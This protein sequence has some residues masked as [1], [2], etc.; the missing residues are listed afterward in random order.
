MNLLVIGS[1]GREHA[2]AW[3]I[4]QSRLAGKVYCAP[5][6]P[7]TAK[8]AENIPIGVL[9]FDQLVSFA[10]EKR[11]DLTVVGPED[12]L[13]NGIVDTFHKHDLKI[14]GPDKKAARL[15]GSKTFAKNLMRKYQ[16]PT[17]DY[18]TFSTPEPAIAF[19]H[20][21]K[22]YP[23]VLKAGGLAAG[24]GVLI[25]DS[26]AEAEAGIRLIM[27]DRTF[28]SAGDDV[29]IEDFLAGEEVSVFAIC[30][31]H[32]FL[33]LSPSQDHKKALDGDQGKNTGGM[34]AY[35]PAPVATVDFIAGVRQKI[36]EP[37]LQAM[38]AEGIPYK[39]LLY[40]GLILTE[41]GPKVL[42]YNCRFGDPETEVVLPLM[43][44]DLVPLLM[45]SAEGDLKNM[46]VSFHKDFALDVVL[47]SGGYPD[48]YQK[49]KLIGGLDAVDPDILIFHAGTKSE[50]NRLITSGGRVLNVVA[51]GKDLQHVRDH[52]YEN[53]EKIYFEDMHYRNDIGYRAL[54]RR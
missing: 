51:I 45:A 4:A 30:D 49:G 16:I 37:T 15:E 1:G 34:G 43:K 31:G 54:T 24:K 13:A 8:I 14:F 29:V 28:G 44:S 9:D 38:A 52:L 53:I 26:A 17:A 5:G 23:V 18:R 39:G 48:H 10:R 7:G 3:K 36:I 47:A 40:F 32:D 22:K 2:L 12:P 27:E 19:L 20:S 46:E 33:L 50:E 25:C 21:R 6:N 41:E 11:I 35:A 42:E